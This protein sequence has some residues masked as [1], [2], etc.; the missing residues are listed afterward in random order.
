MLRQRSQALGNKFSSGRY[1]DSSDWFAT[2]LVR[3]SCSGTF[4]GRVKGGAVLPRDVFGSRHV[5]VER[6]TLLTQHGMLVLPFFRSITRV[7]FRQSETVVNLYGEALCRR[8]ALFGENQ[9]KLGTKRFRV[10][11]FSASKHF[12]TACCDFPRQIPHE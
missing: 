7:R 1:A 6:F 12:T 9:K 5:K 2:G 8:Q 11:G 10:C 3:V 4:W